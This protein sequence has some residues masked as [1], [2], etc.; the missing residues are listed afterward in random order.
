MK[1]KQALIFMSKVPLLGKTKT[2]L[3][4]FLPKEDIKKI[5]EY[6]IKQNFNIAKRVQAD[7]FLYITPENGVD[8]IKSLLKL[9]NEVII[10]QEGDDLGEKMH[11]AIKK[12]Y[13]KGYTDIIL[14]GSDLYG[15]DSDM[16]NNAFELLQKNDFVVGPTMDGG[17]GFIGMHT[18]NK[19][20]FDISKYSDE[21]VLLELEKKI[22]KFDLTFCKTDPIIDIDTRDDIAKVLTGDDKAHF[23][24]EGEY[25]TNFSFDNGTKLLRIAKSSQ[26]NLKHQI[27][28]EYKALLGLQSSGAVPKV[29]DVIPYIDWLGRGYLTEEMVSGRELNY[30][31]DL[32]IAAKLLRK[33]HTVEIDKLDHLIEPNYPLE[34][35]YDESKKMFEVYKKWNGANQNVIELVNTIFHLMEE[36]NMN[37]SAIDPC[38]INTELNSSNFVINPQGRSYII[39]WE[40]PLI[41]DKEQDLAHFLAPTTTLF[42]TSRILS[43]QEMNYFIDCYETNDLQ[44]DKTLLNH[45]MLY[46]CQR[47][48]T[49]SSMAYS[50]YSESGVVSEQKIKKLSA[51]IELDFLEYIIEKFNEGG[52]ITVEN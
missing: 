47:G 15:L 26:M 20:L 14:M 13:Q 35:I 25:N 27:L 16:L 28:Y 41:G 21:N 38:P 8:A 52:F 33:I 7:L 30:D 9:K 36:I 45:Y 44:V 5:S 12:V 6:L 51:Y 18:P 4:N 42:K 29:Y 43:I 31:V 32:K 39:D 24:A 1:N 22:Q 17:Y 34:F 19:A 10:I 23:L 37:K 11:N 50:E 3:N 2:R 40:K 46:T 49:W 48:I